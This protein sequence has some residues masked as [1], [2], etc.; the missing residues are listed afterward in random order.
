MGSDGPSPVATTYGLPSSYYT[1]PGVLA[2]ETARLFTRTWQIVGREEDVPEAGD[3]LT[4]VIG[5]E[6][7]VIVRNDQGQLR[8]MFNVCAH[9]G[10]RLVDGRG[11]SRRITCP[12]HGWTYDLDGQLQG[13]P[14]AKHFPEELDR[15]TVRLH[16][17]EVDTWGG[18]VFVNLDPGAEGLRSYLGDMIGRWEDYH[19]DWNALREVKRTIYNEPCNWKIFMEN[20]TDYYHIPYIHQGTLDMPPLFRN[21][22]SGVH[23]MLTTITPDDDYGRFFDLL[24]PNNYFHVGPNKIQLF[25]VLP[26]TPEASH[27]EIVFYQTPAQMEHYP[28]DDP[29]KHRDADRIL[30]EDFAICRMLQQQAR[31]Q[32]YRVLST[33][34]EFEDGVNHFDNTLLAALA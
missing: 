11:C 16:Q 17:A 18:F 6:P 22:A 3:Y 23:F 13:I 8:A 2:L 12:Y 34:S 27:I 15:S 29:T 10:M 24:F 26:E 32:F 31:S 25:R 1:D 4:C 28:L 14:F 5:G 7:I 19:P 9:R 30:G 20:S 21:Q 33:A